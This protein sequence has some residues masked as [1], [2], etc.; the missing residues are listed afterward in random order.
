MGKKEK[1]K[2][3]P[4]NIYKTYKVSGDKLERSNKSCPKCGPGFA[5]AKHKERSTC[6]K[7]KYTEFNKKE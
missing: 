1:G 4:N 7:C 3:H 2:K 6:G 5:M